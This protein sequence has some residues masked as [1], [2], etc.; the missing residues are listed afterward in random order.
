MKLLSALL[1][2]AVLLPGAV[3]AA[4]SDDSADAVSSTAV[5]AAAASTTVAASA[6]PSTVALGV[7]YPDVRLRYDFHPDWALEAKGSFGNGLQVYSGR[8]SYDFVKIGPLM[9]LAGGEAGWIKFDGIDTVSGSGGYGQ[10]FVGLEYPFAS[11]LKLEA[12]GGPLF[13]QL[14]AEGQSVKT[15]DLVFDAALY[16]YLW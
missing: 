6:E 11:R 3:R 13:A 1:L 15:G 2:A 16:L 4:A 8:L 7:G 9:A 12:D 5:D 10:V 14:N